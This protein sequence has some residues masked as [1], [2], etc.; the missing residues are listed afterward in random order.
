MGGAAV[1]D[2]AIAELI[3]EACF[4]QLAMLY[5]ARCG[6]TNGSQMTCAAIA[7]MLPT[8]SQLKEI[9]MSHNKISLEGMR[10]LAEARPA[11]ALERIVV[12]VGPRDTRLCV[13][14]AGVTEVDVRVQELGEEEVDDV[15]HSLRTCLNML[16]ACLAGNNIGDEKTCAAI[17]EMRPTLSQLKEIDMSRNKISLEGVR[18]LAENH[19]TLITN[20]ITVKGR[21]SYVRVGNALTQPPVQ[22]PTLRSIDLLLSGAAAPTHTICW[23]TADVFVGVVPAAAAGG[24]AGSMGGFYYGWRS[25]PAVHMWESNGNHYQGSSPSDWEG[26]GG[27]KQGDV[28]GLLLDFD[29]GTLTAYKNGGRLGVMVPNAEVKELGAGP[30]C[31]ALDLGAKGDAVRI[32]RGA[33]SM[34]A[35]EEA[36]VAAAHADNPK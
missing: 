1:G 35:A 20:T 4:A 26:G 8:L 24:V 29:H 27:Y 17:A 2:A 10:V 9:D 7:E 16:S 31:W 25:E 13:H 14:D 11:S 12:T 34:T 36:A 5:I 33:P 3:C 21:Y 19:F 28:A 23:K 18:L 6:V 32:A 15:I 22:R 30:F